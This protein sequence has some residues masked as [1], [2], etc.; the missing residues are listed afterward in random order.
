MEQPAE[1]DP[2]VRRTDQT[3]HHRTRPEGTTDHV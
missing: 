1:N 2:A 3:D